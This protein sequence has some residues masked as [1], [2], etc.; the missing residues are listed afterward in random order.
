MLNA[1]W[2]LHF[3]LGQLFLMLSLLAVLVQ[4]YGGTRIQQFLQQHTMI[5]PSVLVDYKAMV[6]EQMYLALLM[7]GLLV[8][9]FF[10]GAY[11]TKSEPLWL[12][13]LIGANLVIMAISGFWLRPQE[14]QVRSLPCATPELETAV[15]H[16]NQCWIYHAWPNF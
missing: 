1:T 12:I 15:Q 6:R 2:P 8:A 14:L 3:D 11:L 7:I 16:I 5:N 13:G 10:L 4:M 9:I